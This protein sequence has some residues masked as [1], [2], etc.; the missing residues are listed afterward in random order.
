M[1]TNYLKLAWS[2]LGRKKFFTF[3]SLFGISFT[4]GILMVMLSFLQ[5]ELGTDRPLGNKDQ[6]TLLESLRLQR[7]LYDTIPKIDTIYNDGIMV[8]DTSY[9]H[10]RTGSMQWNS[11]INNGIA[12]DYLS[13][14]PSVEEMTIFNASSLHDVYVNGV[15]LSLSTMYGDPS[16]WKIF[17]H[18]LIAGRTIDQNDMDQSAKVTVISDKTALD[19]FGTKENVIDREMFIDGKNYKVIGLYPDRSKIIPFISP[20]LVM[21]YTNLTLTDQASFYHGSFN[22][23]FKRKSDAAPKTLNHEITQAALTIPLDHPSK[24]AG[25]NEVIFLPKTYNEMYAQG[26]YGGQ[27]AAKSLRI[28]KII[29]LGLLFFFIVL[30]TLNLIN[31]NVSRIM[32]RSSEIGVRKA[33]GATQGNIV[34]QFIIENILQTVLGGLIGLGIALAYITITNKSGYLGSSTTMSFNPKFFLYA[35]LIT[36]LFGIVSGLLPAYRMSKLNIVNALKEN[37]I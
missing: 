32:E 26:V 21:P 37:K 15:K 31:L 35:F 6:L 4:L 23:V 13:D 30:P 8:Y 2:V 18:K 3:I 36:L 5:G 1:L 19:Y 34:S 11:D 29:L 14:L 33:F 28:M 17:N 7:V 22:V 9:E 20:D 27:D 25:Y 12:E 24:P 10:K 16:Y